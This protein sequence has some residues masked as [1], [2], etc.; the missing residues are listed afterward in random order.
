M[1]TDTHAHL[2]FPDFTDDLSGVLDRAAAA[3]VTRV[4]TIGT[5]VESSRHCVELATRFPNVYAAVGIHPGN[6]HEVEPGWEREIEELAKAPK[7]VALGEM[8]TDYYRL[9]DPES[10]SP[11]NLAIKA[12][13]R[14]VFEF[15][16]DLARRTG[17]GVVIHTRHSL[18]AT[19]EQM[20]PYIGSVKGVFHCFVDG[21]ANLARV[22]AQGHNVS[23][24]GIVTFK[25][26]PDVQA[27][28]VAVPAD[29]FFFETDC[30]Y[31]APVPYRGKRC[32]PA[33]TAN[34]AA[35]VA[36]LRGITLEELA[37]QA[38]RNAEAFFRF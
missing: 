15:Q 2:T 36:E 25:S 18:D 35:K 10:D 21:P 31:L 1:L 33:Y 13:Q 28:A 8:G 4:I 19:L 22:L 24:T 32:E 12:Q 9:P 14:E 17:F 26:A 38:E 23:F 34:T 3:G 30:P 16:L 27:S 20:A 6:A 5:T 37:A 7:V 29:R 11:A